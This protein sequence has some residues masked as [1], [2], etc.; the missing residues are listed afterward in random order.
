MVQSEQ[1]IVFPQ[2]EAD[3]WISLRI[4]RQLLQAVHL[5]QGIELLQRH[6]VGLLK[7]QVLTKVKPQ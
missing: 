7:L 2:S 4:D 5:S 3:N 6:E 1:D